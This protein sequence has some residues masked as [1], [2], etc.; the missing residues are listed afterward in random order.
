MQQQQMNLRLEDTTPIEC[1]KCKGQLF[2]EVT[3]IR[4]A[5]RFVTN[6]P[7]DSMVPIPVFACITNGPFSP[8][9]PYLI[10]LP[11]RGSR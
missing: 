10:A 6:M 3:L 9:L 7:Q 1:D 8:P 5:S 11:L 2:K 4:K